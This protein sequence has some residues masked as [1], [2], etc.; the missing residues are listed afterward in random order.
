MEEGLFKLDGWTR[1]MEHSL[2]DPLGVFLGGGGGLGGGRGAEVELQDESETLAY[3][4][5]H[6][7]QAISLLVSGTDWRG[8]RVEVGGAVEGGGHLW[9]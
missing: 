7:R 6:V 1:E 3:E 4:M 9:E 5:R 8:G 2:L